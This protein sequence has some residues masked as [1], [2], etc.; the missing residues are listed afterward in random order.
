MKKH[1]IF[2]GL[3]LVPDIKKNKETKI[4]QAHGHTQYI[5]IKT[6]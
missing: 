6:F 4:I 2:W 1:Y 3:G 5:H